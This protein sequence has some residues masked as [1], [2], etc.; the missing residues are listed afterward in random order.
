MLSSSGCNYIPVLIYTVTKKTEKFTG[1]IIRIN[2]INDIWCIKKL[3]FYKN[4]TRMKGWISWNLSRTYFTP[5]SQENCFKTVVFYFFSSFALLKKEISTWKKNCIMTFSW[6][7]K[8]LLITVREE[9]NHINGFKSKTTGCIMIMRTE[10]EMCLVFMKIM[11][12]CI[13]IIIIIGLK[14]RLHFIYRE[15]RLKI[16]WKILLLF[17]LKV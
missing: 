15:D 16:L 3:H 6:Q 7:E 2:R 8:A 11:S 17:F 14:N 1:R 12:K 5:K 4:E 10:R 13:I 9:N